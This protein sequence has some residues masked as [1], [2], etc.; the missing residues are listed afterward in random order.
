MA[1][2]LRDCLR[3]LDDV[4][5]AP[6]DAGWKLT[7]AGVGVGSL[8]GGGGGDGDEGDADP[9]FRGLSYGG[10]GRSGG[11]GD[12]GGGM[13]GRYGGGGGDAGGGG[14]GG[15]EGF[16]AGV[17]P[18]AEAAMEG[19]RRSTARALSLPAAAYTT[20]RFSGFGG[21][22]RDDEKDD[23]GGGGRG[24]GGGVN[25]RVSY[26]ANVAA[27]VADDFAGRLRRRVA[28]GDVFG[29]LAV[30]SGRAGAA[31]VGACIAGAGFL[32]RCLAEHGEDA[33]LLEIGA[34]LF[35]EQC[36]VGLCRLNQVDPYPITYSLSNP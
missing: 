28:A 25:A 2:E 24:G 10:D 20:H 15:G 23:G 34:D 18:A 32:S 31:R 26:L 33:A 3:A 11:G 8:D 6:A 35:E 16:T 5:D 7:G 14:G 29:A 19:V 17:P 22:V 12:D 13:R 36:A 1:A 30:G 4:C 9:F 21:D 27:A